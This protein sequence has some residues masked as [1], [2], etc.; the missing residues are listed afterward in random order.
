MLYEVITDVNVIFLDSL[1][2]LNFYKQGAI[3]INGYSK[4]EFDATV[5]S[6]FIRYCNLTTSYPTNHQTDVVITSYSIHYTKL[7][8][9]AIFL[10]FVLR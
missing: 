2:V 1:K 5:D 4:S 10:I 8:E 9:I 3:S 6:V 7:Y